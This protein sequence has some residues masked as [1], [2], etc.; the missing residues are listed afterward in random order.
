MCIYITSFDS[1]HKL[2][3]SIYNLE[4]NTKVNDLTSILHKQI[5]KIPINIDHI[6]YDYWLT[7][8]GY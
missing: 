5:T 1:L 6:L 2:R 4:V 7:K 8:H 3:K